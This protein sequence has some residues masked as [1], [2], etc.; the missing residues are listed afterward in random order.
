LWRSLLHKES[1]TIS[2]SKTRQD[3]PQ[4]LNRAQERY[5]QTLDKEWLYN[6]ELVRLDRWAGKNGLHLLLSITDYKSL[7]YSHAHAENIIFK[8]GKEYLSRALGVSAIV[9]SSDDYIFVMQNSAHV[10]E[11]PGYWDVPGGH[12]DLPAG[13]Q[14]PDLFADIS[15]ELQEELALSCEISQL[16]CMGLIETRQTFKPELLFLANCEI[17]RRDILIEAKNSKDK[18]EFSKLWSLAVNELEDW[19]VENINHISPSALAALHFYKD[20]VRRAS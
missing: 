10:G 2:W 15:R 9:V 3:L 18:F 8:W 19:T 16:T 5:W 6:G 20:Y 17:N 12:V 4:E 1:L 7:L 14:I 11:Y 13:D